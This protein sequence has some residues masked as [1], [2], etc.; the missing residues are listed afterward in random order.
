MTP[1]RR[2]AARGHAVAKVK[3]TD[4]TTDKTLECDLHDIGRG[5]MFVASDAP[6]PVGKRVD[7]EVHTSAGAIAGMG[8]VIWIREAAQGDLP[9]GMGVKFI[10]VDNEALLAID[11]LVGLKKNVRERTVLGMM[12][13]TPPASAPKIETPTVDAPKAEAP[14]VD[15]P[16]A[17]AP[18][19]VAKSRERTMLGIAPP[20]REKELSWPDEPPEPPPEPEPEPEPEPAK[21]TESKSIEPAT[22]TVTEPATV[23]VTEPATVTESVVVEPEPAAPEPVAAVAA[24]KEKEKASIAEPPAPRELPKREGGGGA[25]KWIVLLVVI[26]A[27]G[28][29]VYMLR[30]TIF[31][32]PPVAPSASASAS[33]SASTSAEPSM[34][35]SASE[36][37]T[38]STPPAES[39]PPPTETI[40]PEPTNEAPLTTDASATSHDAGH[41]RD[42]GRHHHDAGAHHARPRPS[43]SAGTTTTDNPY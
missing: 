34:S 21:P 11:R 30:D 20:V 3:L 22:V 40:E 23:T 27:A 6:L 14:K 26:V 37:A 8:R 24:P 43:A 28:V 42:G 41:D 9:A 4:A 1:E 25:L 17:E 7:I 32:G 31:P 12:A 2:T 36:S 5:G 19:P 35:A 16:K 29:A 18:R 13:P 33:A 10:D 15:A 39:A 38:S